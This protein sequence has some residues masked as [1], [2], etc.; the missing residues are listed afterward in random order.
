MLLCLRGQV[1]GHRPQGPH[2]W[3]HYTTIL[4]PP[5]KL[6]PQTCIIL[7]RCRASR[8]C[9]SSDSTDPAERSKINATL[10]SNSLQER[11]IQ[12]KNLKKRLLQ[13]TEHKSDFHYC[14]ARFGSLFR[15]VKIAFVAGYRQTYC[16]ILLY[17]THSFAPIRGAGSVIK[18]VEPTRS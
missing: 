14:N 12:N 4:K 3:P 16:Y 15:T 8:A 6:P 18:L 7:S 5:L 10:C 9:I 2:L 11:S 17:T 1:R 13:R